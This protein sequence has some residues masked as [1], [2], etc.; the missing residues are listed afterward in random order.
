MQFGS[1]SGVRYFIPVN[2]VQEFHV[3]CESEKERK[4]DFVSKDDYSETNDIYIRIP[5]DYTI[6]HLPSSTQLESHGHSFSQEIKMDGQFICVK[7]IRKTVPVRL[8]PG[9]YNELC[10][11]FNAI[12]KANN[13][14]IVIIKSK[15]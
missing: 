4:T 12:R 13:Q 1:A 5:R 14:K 9:Q 8:K 6:E 2:A 3:D 15:S 11:F 7:N 10:S